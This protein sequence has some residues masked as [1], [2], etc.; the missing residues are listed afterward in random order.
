MKL[1]AL[2]SCSYE[3][4]GVQSPGYWVMRTVW[5]N[6]N[7]KARVRYTEL[8]VKGVQCGTD[9]SIPLDC[10]DAGLSPQREL[11]H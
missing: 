1:R 7:A 9:C 10:R 8:A 4:L 3:L 11:I 6:G 5:L 2:N